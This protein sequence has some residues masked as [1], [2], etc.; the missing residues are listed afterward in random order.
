VLLET[1]LI[2][3]W[4]LDKNRLILSVLIRRHNFGFFLNYNM[5]MNTSSPKKSKHQTDKFYKKNPL[6]EK[7]REV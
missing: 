6:E 3:P 2:K 4:N 7:K 5:L 1:Q